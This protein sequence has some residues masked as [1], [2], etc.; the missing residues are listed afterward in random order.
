V[1]QAAVALILLAAACGEPARPSAPATTTDVARRLSAAYAAGDAPAAA[2]LYAEDAVSVRIGGAAS[3]GRAAIESDLRRRFARH[4]QIRLAIGRIW[5]DPSASAIE[6]VFSGTADGGGS[7]IGVVGAHVVHFD[8]RGLVRSERVYFDEVTEVG[9]RSATL[10]PAGMKVRPVITEPPAG[11]AVVSSTGSP[12]ERRN[13]EV[14]DRIWA[15][16]DAHD[17]AA[18]LAPMADDYRYEDFAAPGPLDRSGTREM[19]A[20]FLEVVP[21]FRIAE[22]PVYF[23]AGREVVSEIVERATRNG[24][25]I[26]LHALDVRQFSG[27]RVVREWQ[28]ANHQEVRDQLAGDRK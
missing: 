26:T 18:A 3:R 5:I 21:D 27:G 16:L 28:Y 7:P 13:L 20:R 9:Q 4:R 11:T 8:R 19:V 2:A 25:P 14:S 17:P 24:S 12:E 1:S 15:A 23:A 10:L 22:K 6:V